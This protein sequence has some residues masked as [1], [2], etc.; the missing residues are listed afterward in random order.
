MLH[1]WM[2]CK[3][4]IHTHILTGFFTPLLP[5]LRDLPAL[6]VSPNHDHTGGVADF[7][8]NDHAHSLNRVVTP[9]HVVAQEQII[10]VRRRARNLED[11][12]EVV[13]LAVRV[14]H[15]H[16][17]GVDVSNIGLCLQQLLALGGQ[18]HHLIL[19]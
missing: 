8:G 10:C 5:H 9:V 4:S 7:E 6:V 3:V 17:G 11:F 16:D 12:N 19:S 15:D 13:E 18:L 1:K 2:Q 14:A